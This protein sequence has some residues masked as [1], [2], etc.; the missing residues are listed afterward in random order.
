MV[1][2]ASSPDG[3]A[4]Q[5]SSYTQLYSQANQ[6]NANRA[7]QAQQQAIQDALQQQQQDQSAYQFDQGEN[8]QGTQAAADRVQ[9]AKD[10]ATQYGSAKQN[11]EDMMD[12][13]NFQLA[14]SLAERG[15]LPDNKDDIESQ[16][17]N[18]DDSDIA[19]LT[20]VNGSAK[21]S[22]YQTALQQALRNGTAPP[23]VDTFLTP[24]SPFYDRAKGALTSTMAPI[25]SD[26]AKNTKAANTANLEA[27]IAKDV[28]APPLDT[29][30]NPVQWWNPVSWLA[31]IH[32]F[33]IP[34]VTPDQQIQPAGNWQQRAQNVTA[35]L[36]NPKTGP[37]LQEQAGITVDPTT[38]NY[39]PLTVPSAPRT[40]I[41]PATPLA[42]PAPQAVSQVPPPNQRVA[43]QTYQLPTGNFTWTGTGWVRA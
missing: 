43:G 2:Y 3:L 37:S 33:G 24:N 4:A 20:T 7:Q 16:Y 29:D 23:P 6:D 17:P 39:V 1:L 38:G 19:T 22:N 36:T 25:L 8:F 27:N 26:V 35:A 28:A 30:V 5:Q 32:K 12:Q 11:R 31:G 21:Y 9:R 34:S 13:K 41:A 15:L 14:T 18:L 10:V 42:A 40:A